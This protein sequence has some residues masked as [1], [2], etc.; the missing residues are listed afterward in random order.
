MF[1]QE[2]KYYLKAFFVT[3]IMALVMFLPFVI[4][5]GGYFIFYGDY[6]AQQI[7]FFK[8]CVEA[9]HNGTF[10]WDWKTDLGANFFGSY[11]YY[12]LGSPFFWFMCLFPASWAPYLMMPLLCVKFGLFGLF[13]FIYIRRFVTKPQ[14]A[15]IGGILYAFSSFNLYNVFFQ[16]QDAMIWFPLLLIGLEEA[17]I[18]K[19]RGVFALA[20]AIN[21][22]ANYFF[23]IQECV[24]LV[25]YFTVR[26]AVD[27]KFILKLKDF[28]ALAFECVVGVLIAGVL[29]FPSIY[30]VLD[31]PRSTNALVNW[32]FLFFGDE[33]RYG[34]LVESFFFPPEIAA[35]NE[36]FKNANAKWSSVALYLPLFSMAGVLA[37]FKS[38]KKHWVKPL[39][40]VCLLF[41][42]I[43]GL[44]SAFTM[45]NNNYY[46]R[47]F[48][49]PTLICCL[50]TA[51]A[52]EHKEVDLRFGLKA[53]AAATLFI[54]VIVLITPFTKKEALKVTGPEENNVIPRFMAITYYPLWIA[55]GVAIASLIAVL[56]LLNYRKKTTP[57]S[58]MSCATALT[59]IFSMVLGYYF[60][61]CGR[62]IG[63]AVGRFN[64]MASAEF[65]ID[66]DEFYRIE[67][68]DETN[69][70][71]MFWGMSSLKSFT[72]IVP[73]STFEF[74]ELIRPMSGNSARS[75]N[76][77]PELDR[78]ALRA[79]TNVKYI[80]IPEDMTSRVSSIDKLEIYDYY[81]T[82][83]YY[84][85]YKTDYALPMGFAYDEYYLTEDV[86]DNRR[87]DNLM[88]RAAV[89]TE[90]QADEYS[91]IL[92]ALTPY[93]SGNIS[94]DEFKKDAQNRIDE[95]VLSFEVTK[96]GF[97]SMTNYDSEKLV[98]FSV[99][100]CRGWSATINGEPVK[101]DKINGGLI[102][103]RV[104][105]G[106][107]DI[108]FSYETPYLKYGIIA[109][110]A[111]VVIFGVYMLLIKIIKRKNGRPY[112]HLYEQEQV[113]EVKAHK[114]YI[115]QLSDQIYNCFERGGKISPDREIEFPDIN[116]SFMDRKKYDFS[117]LK[118]KERE[119][120]ITEDDEAYRVM[121]ELDKQKKENEEE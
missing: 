106:E 116:E 2:K 31:V 25:I 32:H 78:Y 79:L 4:I 66:D 97:N 121:E 27:P 44:N 3:M 47:W 89:L 120:H 30:Q 107:C 112:V 6:N 13:A 95:G 93:S 43:P 61:G 22:L 16:F 21:C 105:K 77:A 62:S 74:Y 36:M 83:G 86:K 19:R 88:V 55:I 37:F 67:G 71:N 80:M 96:A 28:F 117:K 17:V 23:F 52:L 50:A 40:L 119:Y 41:A 58:F 12:T 102:G 101:V 115:N 118:P 42:F 20:M 103:V 38:V 82:Q 69:N 104:P 54:T 29:F 7:P 113:E 5:D 48:Y 110:A 85:I 34:L 68:L 92:E 51:Y 94:V 49:M 35:R 53:T 99:P 109:S 76:S 9:V 84:D 81:D 98:C 114:S 15:L 26:Y 18:N 75:V 11:T 14:S 60:I 70:V 72:S 59:I 57:A 73:G 100:W 45:F 64:T 10:G 87:V 46:T 91:D 24:F 111:G 56:I 1:K 90:E 63:P 8:Q 39:L 108:S 65:E 33:Q